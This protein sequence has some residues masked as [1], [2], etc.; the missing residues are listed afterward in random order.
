[1]LTQK[2]I[3]MTGKKRDGGKIFPSMTTKKAKPYARP[4]GIYFDTKNAN[5]LTMKTTCA[6]FL[7]FLLAGCSGGIHSPLVEMDMSLAS[8]ILGLNG[9][10]QVVYPYQQTGDPQA[11]SPADAFGPSWVDLQEEY[12]EYK[13]NP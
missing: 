9:G 13:F 12:P 1:M 6:L 10:T 8:P 11:G 5:N 2:R 3:H 4:N 7:V